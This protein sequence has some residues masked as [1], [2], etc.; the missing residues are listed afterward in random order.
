M[1][2]ANA[3][4][5]LGNTRPEVSPPPSFANEAPGPI[6][7][8][9]RLSEHVQW[10]IELEHFTIPPYLCAL[11]SLDPG[12]NPDAA[13]VIRTVVIEEML[14]MTLAANLLNAVGGRPQ[15][16]VPQMLPGYPGCL[17]HS[18]QSFEVP[19]MRFC[20]EALDVFL[21]I[22]QPSAPGGPPLGECYETI[23]QFYSAIEHGLRALCARHGEAAVFSGDPSRQVTNE[24]YAGGGGRIIP[25]HDLATAL[26]ALAEIVEQGEG[27]EQ[28][29]IWDRSCNLDDPA[30]RELAHFYRFEELKLGRRY[31]P[32]VTPPA[33][34]TGEPLTV[35]W[36]G[37]RRMRSNPRTGDHAP[38]SPIRKAQDDFNTAYCEVLGL[39]DQAFDGM[40]H[41]LEFAIGAMYGLSE[42]AD[43]LMRV[44]DTET[45]GAWMAGPSFEYVTPV[46]RS[47][48]WPQPR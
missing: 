33:G 4:M 8:L 36:D 9:A 43:A 23:G 35:D 2:S 22:E 32:G 24:L 45:D 41:L 40:P 34:P 30:C 13:E 20:P 38:G 37:V 15:V 42:M 21:M 17:P 5:P 44:P 27:A 19:L 48:G 31:L 1:I 18:N 3:H 25:I 29:D 10:A 11:F 6:D 28:V 14:H 12:R 26:D 39:L 7:S 46:R 16:D 47:R